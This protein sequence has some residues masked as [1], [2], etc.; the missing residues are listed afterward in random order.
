MCNQK[1]RLK[2]HKHLKMYMFRI[3]EYQERI[4]NERI[5]VLLPVFLFVG[6]GIFFAQTLS[7]GGFGFEGTK[8]EWAEKWRD[9]KSNM[10]GKLKENSIPKTAYT[11]L[12]SP[13]HMLYTHAEQIPWPI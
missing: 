12:P 9:L 2:V 6:F 7:N 1:L 3:H 4:M 10:G 11:L 5:S 8:G 13:L